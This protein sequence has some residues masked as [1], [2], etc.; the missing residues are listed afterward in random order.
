[1]PD[2]LSIRVDQ[3]NDGLKVALVDRIDRSA[4]G[5]YTLKI[6]TLM[7]AFGYRA[8]QRLR[9]SSLLEVTNQLTAWGISATLPGDAAASDWITLSHA[10][11]PL[12]SPA[13]TPDVPLQRPAPNMPT[14]VLLS[15]DDRVDPCANPFAF[16]F[17]VGDVLD[18][19]RSV[20]ICHDILAAV[21]SFRPVCLHV[22]ASDEFFSFAAGFLSAVMRRRAL[23]V[24]GSG[25]W[26]PPLPIAPEILSIEGLKALIRRPGEDGVEAR[27]PSRNA[28]YLMRDIPND[29]QDDGLIASVREMFVPH[30]YR[31][32]GRFTTTTAEPGAG[33]CRARDDEGFQSVWR[34]IC[35]FAGAP[36]LA[37]QGTAEHFIDLASLFAEAAQLG[38]S[39]LCSA[40]QREVDP[41]FRAGF[42][43]SEHMLLKSS[44]LRHLRGAYPGETLAVEELMDPSE[45]EDT[46][47]GFDDPPGQ[48]DAGASRIKPDIRMGAMLAVEVETLRSLTLLG[49]NAFFGL[50]CK[51]RKKLA[52]LKAVNEVWL[53]VPSD[54]AML[55]TEHLSAVVRSLQRTADVPKFRLAYVDLRL[56]RPVFF[57]HEPLPRADV[58]LSGA[59][60]RES[61][62]PPETKRLTWKDVAGYSDL[63]RCIQEDVLEPLRR[64]EKYSKYGIGAP[65][66]LLLYGLPGC[67][68]SRIGRVLAGE[69]DLVCKLIAPSD[70]TSMWLGE[71]TMKIRELF[72]WALKQA[73]CMLI[74]DEID[75][76]APQ[77]QEAN[78]HTD[79]K[80]QVNELL[81]QL[82]RIADKRVAVVATTNYAGGIDAAIRR[83]GR[84]DMKIPVFPPTVDDRR[85][86]FDHYLSPARLP[87]VNGLHEMDTRALAEETLLYTPA[88]IKTIVDTALR[89]AVFRAEN[90][91]SPRIDIGDLRE[92]VRTQPRSIQR[93][94]AVIWIRETRMELGSNEEALARLEAEVTRVY[95]E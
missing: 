59:S 44:L 63:K 53:V 94:A 84:F 61:R 31:L 68:K 22:E 57:Y 11:A 45:A 5:K 1:M 95:G 54:V 35:A 26:G 48:A 47:A 38:E 81:A 12:R 77:R 65:N 69:A 25:T 62:K 88:D 52:A 79:E 87:E 93:E 39:L 85:E 75:A 23:M 36:S 73:P 66:G 91:A 27:F 92:V 50:E 71:G 19:G 6:R 60:W 7:E 9:Q 21:W 76:I 42:E 82:D 33:G 17:N 58:K 8:V 29:V 20:A 83:S 24:R 4:R 56:D 70:L 13:R 28:V 18:R 16:A 32:K 34:W 2:D 72:D 10:D 89:R 86:I 14:P 55:A 40:A 46:A 67:G 30:T 37:D 74:I 15:T 43:S 78:M 90:D 41:G 51:L 49:S 80:R 3:G 64:P